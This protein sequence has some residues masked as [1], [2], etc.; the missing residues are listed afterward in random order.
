MYVPHSVTSGCGGSIAE[1]PPPI[2]S[3]VST[4]TGLK[5][6]G[7]V[8]IFFCFLFLHE[9]HNNNKKLPVRF[10]HPG[11]RRSV[12]FVERGR[13]RARESLGESGNKEIKAHK[14]DIMGLHAGA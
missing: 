8:D 7:I 14:R 4:H 5:Q 6:F 12:P 11:V 13:E 2:T 9:D 10:P 1:V 3:T